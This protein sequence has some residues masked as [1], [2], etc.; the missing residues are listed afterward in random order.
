MKQPIICSE[1]DNLYFQLQYDHLSLLDNLNSSGIYN[2]HHLGNWAGTANGDWRDS[3][4]AGA[5]NTWNVILT[6]GQVL[7]AVNGQVNWPICGVHVALVRMVGGFAFG[8]R[9]GSYRSE[10]G[11]GER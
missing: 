9:S 6:D 8:H 5:A 7:M 11:T 2:K 4:L 10:A 1:D 3:V